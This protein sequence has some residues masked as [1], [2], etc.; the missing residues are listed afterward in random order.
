MFKVGQKVSHFMTTHKAGTVIHIEYE[1]NNF[2]T[3][4]GTTESKVIIT[5]QYL[6]NDIQKHNSGDLI[7]VYD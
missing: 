4:G 1:K 3:T 5:V 7:K 2:M 6:E